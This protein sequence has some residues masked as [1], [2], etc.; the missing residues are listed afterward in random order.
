MIK[1]ITIFVENKFGR[2]AKII[3]TIGKNNIDISALSIAD[4][5]DYGI[6]R[7]IVNDPELTVKVLK[8]SGVIAKITD[9]IA[10]AID[11]RP[12]GL[13]M[14]VNALTENEIS[15]DYL[16]AF[17]GKIEGKALMVVKTDNMDKTVK[18][19]KENNI[20]IHDF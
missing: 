1:Q 18:V 11:D 12:S 2:F 16:Y 10:V 15:I 19:L 13:S 17:T 7:M 20:E 8:E 5:T 9:V 4:T 14:V 3:E 6:I